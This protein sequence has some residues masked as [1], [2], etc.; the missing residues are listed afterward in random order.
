MCKYYNIR[1]ITNT[2][3][4]IFSIRLEERGTGIKLN[5]R[6]PIWQRKKKL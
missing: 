1:N 2:K 6:R 5:K 3:N 4:R